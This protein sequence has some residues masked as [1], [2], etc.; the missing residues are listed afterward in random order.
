MPPEQPPPACNDLHGGPSTRLGLISLFVVAA[1]LLLI[2]VLAVLVAGRMR[3]QT[4][5]IERQ[6]AAI[7]DLSRRIAQ[8]ESRPAR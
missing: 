3:L 7:D 8:L 4:A 5:V 2:I 6:S 1:F